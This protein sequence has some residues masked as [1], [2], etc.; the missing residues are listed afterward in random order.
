MQGIILIHG[1]NVDVTTLDRECGVYYLD[2][3][4]T[5][6][7]QSNLTYVKQLYNINPNDNISTIY[8][9]GRLQKEGSAYV[10]VLLRQYNPNIYS[11]N[12]LSDQGEYY[13]GLSNSVQARERSER[14]GVFRT[15]SNSYGG[16]YNG[17]YEKFYK[18][19]ET[20]EA[21]EG[22]D[23]PEGI[24]VTYG[25]VDDAEFEIYEEESVYQVHYATVQDD[26]VI[27]LDVKGRQVEEGASEDCG[28]FITG[29]LKN[30]ES[31]IKEYLG[32]DA[33]KEYDMEIDSFA[34]YLK[35]EDKQPETEGEENVITRGERDELIEYSQMLNTIQGQRD[36]IQKSG[37][38]KRQFLLKF[39][40]NAKGTYFEI[41][42]SE[43]SNYDSEEQV[44]GY[45]VSQ[46]Y[47]NTQVVKEIGSKKRGKG[48]KK[49]V[50]NMVEGRYRITRMSEFYNQEPLDWRNDNY[51]CNQIYTQ[52]ADNL[53]VVVDPEFSAKTKVIKTLDEK[54]RRT[55]QEMV[56]FYMISLRE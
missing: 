45:Y 1:D 40:Q 29:F 46:G 35:P 26:I 4:L 2:S 55:E 32:L 34:A 24:P 18:Y 13:V 21:S 27:G 6:W 33:S 54:C 52:N 37:N 15:P 49:A 47:G 10:S 44:Y 3:Q 9:A 48:S 14:W 22:G 16:Q 8:S 42:G 11:K 7:I 43:K 23:D 56:G 50:P 25:M 20:L 39:M 12:I 53:N 36:L 51:Y 5:R 41:L 31:D 30:I 28:A 17:E 19:V 38:A